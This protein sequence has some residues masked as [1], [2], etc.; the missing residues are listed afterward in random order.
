MIEQ[1]KEAKENLKEII[2]NENGY[3]FYLELI[4][5]KIK[6]INDFKLI[7]DKVFGS[8]DEVFRKEVLNAIYDKYDNDSDRMYNICI[9]DLAMDVLID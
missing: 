4:S 1:L 5:E 9:V 7:G 8:D 3:D 6:W 2:I